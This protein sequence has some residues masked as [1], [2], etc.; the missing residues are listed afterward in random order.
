[1]LALLLSGAGGAADNGEPLPQ[2]LTLADALRHARDVPA[3]QRAGA[4]EQAAQAGLL[5]AESLSGTRLTAV[6]RLRAIEPTYKSGNDDANDS[7]ASLALRKRLYD[8]GYSDA[9]ETSAQTA[10]QASQWQLQ[11]ARQQARL[12]VMRAYFDVL[13]ADL[14]FARDN[15]HMAIAF[16]SADRARDRN[17]LGQV[18]DVDLLELESEFQEVRRKRFASETRQVLTRS[19]LANAM[20][21]PGDLVSDLVMPQIELPDSMADDFGAFWQQV[22]QDNPEL[23]GLRAQR[24]AAR[25]QLTAARAAHGPV[26]SGEIDA[27]WYNRNTASTHPL[28]GGLVLEVPLFSGGAKD[29]EIAAAQAQLRE[30]QAALTEAELRLRQQAMDLWMGRNNIRADVQ[31]F[32]VMRDYRD[33]YLDRSRALYELELK[34]DLGDAMTQTS[35]VRLKLAGALFD[36]AMTQAR[37]QAMTGRLLEEQQ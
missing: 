18:S 5:S 23:L 4:A 26:L 33:L 9:L 11:H 29:A 25:E 34:T 36:W 20:G 17:E 13:L 28:G 27:T 37:M 6:G 24:E 15:E 22:M 30:V 8:F 3:L 10:L 21:R 1:M 16:I 7:S 32:E 14:E 35:D 19:R 12:A 31:A 2:P